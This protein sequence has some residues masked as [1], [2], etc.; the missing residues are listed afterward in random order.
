MKIYYNDDMVSMKGKM[1][2]VTASTAETDFV[3]SPLIKGMNKSLELYTVRK[4]PM[5]SRK[6]VMRDGI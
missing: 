3:D 5:L 4:I 2:I 1:S 6:F